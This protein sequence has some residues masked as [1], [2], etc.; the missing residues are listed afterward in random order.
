MRCEIE[1][2]GSIP[3]NKTE[4]CEKI[5]VTVDFFVVIEN[6]SSE[7]LHGRLRKVKYVP[8]VTVSLLPVSKI[9]F[10]PELE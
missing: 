7:A 3:N 9:I 5:V 8:F 6:F 2:L 4:G 1:G 10:P